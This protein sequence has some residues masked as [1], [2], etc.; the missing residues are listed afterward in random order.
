MVSDS[1]TGGG[2]G[3]LW[4]GLAGGSINILKEGKLEATCVKNLPG[5]WGVLT[6]RLIVSSI[7][8]P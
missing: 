2:Q 4:L 7:S 6:S 3:P 1:C 8:G 5:G